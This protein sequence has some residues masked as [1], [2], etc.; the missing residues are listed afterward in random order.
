MGET[1]ALRRERN[2]LLADG[3]HATWLAEAVRRDPVSAG[4][5]RQLGTSCG[6]GERHVLI[7]GLDGRLND[8][9]H[10]DQILDEVLE[11]VPD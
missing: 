3:L 8:P 2:A 7:D 6:V 10:L 9:P 1:Y 5:R 11:G 4:A